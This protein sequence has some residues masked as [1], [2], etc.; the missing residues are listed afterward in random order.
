MW[1]GKEKKIYCVFGVFVVGVVEFLVGFLVELEVV[2]RLLEVEIF[3][4][5][6][7]RVVVGDEEEEG[8][9]GRVVVVMEDGILEVGVK[10]VL[11]WRE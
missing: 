10:L 11:N 4:M 6:I 8:V 5:V 1:K 2:G 3:V 7:E 9:E